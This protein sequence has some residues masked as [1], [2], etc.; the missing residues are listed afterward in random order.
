VEDI[1]LG[2]SPLVLA[3]AV[4]VACAAVCEAIREFKAA[5]LVMMSAAFVFYIPLSFVCAGVLYT[6]APFISRVPAFALGSLLAAIPA[7]V[8]WFAGKKACRAWR[9]RRDS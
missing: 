2:T 1:L 8:G 3:V 5:R 4:G 7:L 6:H 9:E